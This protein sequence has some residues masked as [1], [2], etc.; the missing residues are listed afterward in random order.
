MYECLFGCAFLCLCGK[1]LIAKPMAV[2]EQNKWLLASLQQCIQRRAYQ[3]YAE[4]V[5]LGKSM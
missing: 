1:A 2:G 3:F 4:K 5:V